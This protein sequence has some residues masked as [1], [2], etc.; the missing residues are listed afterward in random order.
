MAGKGRARGTLSP[1]SPAPPPG[2]ATAAAQ[3]A[4]GSHTREAGRE[5]GPWAESTM[6]R[7]NQEILICE[8]GGWNHQSQSRTERKRGREERRATQVAHI[9]L[10]FLVAWFQLLHLLVV[11][12]RL[13]EAKQKQQA[14]A[15]A[16]RYSATRCAVGPGRTE[17]KA[18]DRARHARQP[19]QRRARQ[20][21]RAGSAG[22]VAWRAC[23]WLCTRVLASCTPAVVATA[24]AQAHA[25]GYGRSFPGPALCYR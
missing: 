24:R 19:L 21:A 18:A 11:A 10:N 8:P 25:V 22:G 16:S 20:T 9:G 2:Q 13:L 23:P 12:Q 3:Q 14:T 6:G 5:R 7:V 1:V 15:P 17:G 4:A